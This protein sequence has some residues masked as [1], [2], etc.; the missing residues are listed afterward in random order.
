MSDLGDWY[1]S[2]NTRV[3]QALCAD[4]HILLEGW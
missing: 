2:E 3:L 4:T 1:F